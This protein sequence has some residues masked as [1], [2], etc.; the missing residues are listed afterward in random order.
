M[1]KQI[2][3]KELYKIV[4]AEITEE[5]LAKLPV[6]AQ[7]EIMALSS[8][9][10][11]LN[12]MLDNTDPTDLWIDPPVGDKKRYLDPHSRLVFRTDHKTEISIHMPHGSNRVRISKDTCGEIFMIPTGGNTMEVL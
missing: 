11:R 2:L 8:K 9:I 7:R 5:R 10:E 3:R 12:N 6:W 4:S 1:A